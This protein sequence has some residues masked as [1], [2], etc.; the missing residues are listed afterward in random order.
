MMYSHLK[1][2]YDDFDFYI[3]NIPIKIIEVLSKTF[4]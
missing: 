3:L 1:L 2:K 4:F